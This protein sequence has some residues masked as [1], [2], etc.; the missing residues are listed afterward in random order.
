MS[1]TKVAL[2][3]TESTFRALVE[4]PSALR[5]PGGDARIAP[6]KENR[7]DVFGRKIEVGG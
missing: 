4:F 3:A 6:F 7:S 1:S 5:I 2:S